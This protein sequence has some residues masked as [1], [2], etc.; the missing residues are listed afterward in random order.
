MSQVSLNTSLIR[1]VESAVDESRYSTDITLVFF[2][3]FDPP[4]DALS[5]YSP[6]NG[7]GLF[8][9]RDRPVVYNALG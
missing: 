3:L 2:G 5:S 7:C 1:A 8:A 6:A 9:V 4:W